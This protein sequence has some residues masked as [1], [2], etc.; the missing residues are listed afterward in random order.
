M[1]IDLRTYHVQP[2]TMDRHMQLYAE[3]GYDVQRKHLGEP[4]AY[5]LTESG[6]DVNAYVHI[7]AYRDAADRERKR[8]NLRNDPGWH[9]MQ[10][11]SAAAGY[12]VRQENRLMTP[13]PF[14][15]FPKA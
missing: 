14:F 6:A 1:L 4:I 8:T 11:L 10:R 15:A 2:N 12:L 13:A 3:H 5:L 9:E 7:W